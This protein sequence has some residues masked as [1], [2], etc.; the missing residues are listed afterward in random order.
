[1]ESNSSTASHIYFVG[2]LDL[3]LKSQSQPC[4][5]SV[6]KGHVLLNTYGL[7]LPHSTIKL[8]TSHLSPLMTFAVDDAIYTTVGYI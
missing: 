8:P 5:E 7:V 3:H 1:M 2:A 4:S 6:K